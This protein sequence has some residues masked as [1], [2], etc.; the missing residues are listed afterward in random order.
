M[1]MFATRETIASAADDETRI[2]SSSRDKARSSEVNGWTA[3]RTLALAETLT[4]VT[5]AAKA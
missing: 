1:T 3:G 5:E 4:M 2:S